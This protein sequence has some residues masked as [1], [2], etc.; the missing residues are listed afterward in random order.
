MDGILNAKTGMIHKRQPERSDGR[1]VCGATN[2]VGHDHLE[3]MSVQR[4]LDEDTATKCG[5][6]FADAGGY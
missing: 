4:A 3:L 2:H 5:R 6:C 1:T